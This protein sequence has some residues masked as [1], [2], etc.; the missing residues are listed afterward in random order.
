MTKPHIFPCMTKWCRICWDANY[1]KHQQ[2]P[3]NR[4][5]RSNGQ[6]KN[7]AVYCGPGA[8]YPYAPT[9]EQRKHM[10]WTCPHPQMDLTCNACLRH[11]F[12]PR[13]L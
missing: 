6:W 8:F 13:E 7:V 3:V 5:I 10:S 9:R 11:T 12:R 1:G 4:Y 2:Y